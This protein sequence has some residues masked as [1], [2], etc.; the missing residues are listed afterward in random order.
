MTNNQTTPQPSSAPNPIKKLTI[1][2]VAQAQRPKVIVALWLGI[3]SLVAFFIPF[4]GLALA[5]TSLILVLIAIIKGLTTPLAYAVA[6][7]A[8]FSVTVGILLIV[9][10]IKSP[11]VL[12]V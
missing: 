3:I 9:A 2:P 11:I 1:S 6:V 8:M 4:V 12:P 5:V 10:F 7:I